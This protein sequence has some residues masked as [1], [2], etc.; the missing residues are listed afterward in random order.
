MCLLAAHLPIFHLNG[1][2][3]N[4]VDNHKKIRTIPLGLFKVTLPIIK[5][6]NKN[7]FDKFA[8]FIE[9]MQRETIAPQLGTMTFEDYVKLKKN[10]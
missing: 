2:L 7:T 3:Q 6:F 1:C 5:L 8:F 4:E 10:G 9:V